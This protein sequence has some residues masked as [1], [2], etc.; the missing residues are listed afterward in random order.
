MSVNPSTVNT[1]PWQAVDVNSTVQTIVAGPAHVQYAK[2]DNHDGAVRY[3]QFF[4]VLA[5]D[6]VLGTTPSYFVEVP[7]NGSVIIDIPNGIFYNG[8]ALS[9]AATTTPAGAVNVTNNMYA[10]VH[11]CRG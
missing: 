2:L 10:T 4:N 8:V 9:I 11:Y 5:A 7:A 6:V 3:A 1:I